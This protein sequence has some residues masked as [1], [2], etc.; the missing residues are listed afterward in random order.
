MAGRPW[1]LACQCRVPTAALWLP[2]RLRKRVP[3]EVHNC[4]DPIFTGKQV[5]ARQRALLSRAGD[6]SKAAESSGWHAAVLE[7]GGRQGFFSGL[8]SL[9]KHPAHP[10]TRL[11]RRW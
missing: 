9:I 7:A 10:C 6:A 4:S 3:K 8:P 11:R 2:H 5:G 1:Q